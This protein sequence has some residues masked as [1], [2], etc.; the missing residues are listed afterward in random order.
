MSSYLQK[1]K[2]GEG[3]ATLIES[4]FTAHHD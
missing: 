4:A 1:L 2:L 3:T